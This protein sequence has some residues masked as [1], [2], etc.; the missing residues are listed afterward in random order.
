MSYLD[1]ILLV[2]F[3]LVGLAG[4]VGLFLLGILGVGSL[5]GLSAYPWYIYAIVIAIIWFALGLRFLF[6]RIGAPDVD[7]VVLPGEIG[8]IRIS[9]E[10]IRQLTNRTGKSVRGVQEFDTRVKNG[11]Q[12]V[13]LALRVR[14]LADMDLNSMS[15]E[16]QA[17]VKEYVEET[18]GVTVDRVTVHIAELANSAAKAGRAWVD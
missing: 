14:A 15:K 3:S 10:T 18:T 11:P 2:I 6:Y 13:L 4:A 7:F 9:F 8:N 16:I 17:K 5:Q 1:R 12:G